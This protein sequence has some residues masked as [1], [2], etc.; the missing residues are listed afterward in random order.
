MLPATPKVP[1]GHALQLPK[2]STEYPATHDVVTPVLVLHAVAK[3]EH[4][5]HTFKPVDDAKVRTEHIEHVLPMALLIV[6]DGHAPHVIAG[7]VTPNPGT[8]LEGTSPVAASHAFTPVPIHLA[9]VPAFAYCPVG[10]S[11]QFPVVLANED[12]Q[13]KVTPVVAEQVWAFASGHTAQTD[14]PSADQVPAA[15]ALHHAAAVAVAGMRMDPAKQLVIKPEFA[16]QEAA[17]ERQAV[18]ESDAIVAEN[19]KAGQGVHTP[20]TPNVPLAHGK[21]AA[22]EVS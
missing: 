2:A 11:A 1:A 4:G 14:E 20:S 6:P 13:V 16:A 12:L 10:Q 3:E 19:V 9:Q 17:E 18:Q 8:Q 22:V 5:V 21:Q 7:A 15:H